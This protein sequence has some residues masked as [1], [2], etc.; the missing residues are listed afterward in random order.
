MST[1]NLHQP[2]YGVE[3]LSGAIEGAGDLLHSMA[4][5]IRRE[6]TARQAIRKL[7]AMSDRQLADMGIA[8][9]DIRTAVRGR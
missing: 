8:R 4:K 1:Y 9:R 7:D 5:T 6:V 2:H 3:F